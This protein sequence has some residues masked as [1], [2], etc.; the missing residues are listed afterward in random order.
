[1]QDGALNLGQAVAAAQRDPEPRRI[2]QQAD[3]RLAQLAA[4]LPAGALL[5]VV[6]G[7]GN[8]AL[9]RALHGEGSKRK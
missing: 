9:C 5:L 2:L 3:Q 7:Q 6:S 4:A 8:T 1:M